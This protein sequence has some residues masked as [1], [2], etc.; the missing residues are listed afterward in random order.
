M[1]VLF[2]LSAEKGAGGERL[3]AKIIE[4]QNENKKFK[5]EVLQ[6]KEHVQQVNMANNPTDNG[7]VQQVNM[8]YS[9][10]GK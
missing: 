2:I 6:L 4:L 10:K 8:A 5:E 7:R 9:R 3:Q 1:F